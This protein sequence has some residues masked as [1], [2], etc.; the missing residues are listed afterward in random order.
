MFISRDIKT[1]ARWNVHIEE[2]YSIFQEE[3]HLLNAIA[4]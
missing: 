4:Y 1:Q 3:H 2:Q